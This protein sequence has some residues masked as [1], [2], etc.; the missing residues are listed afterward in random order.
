MAYTQLWPKTF[1]IAA[2]ENMLDAWRRVNKMSSCL[3]A[4]TGCDTTSKIA[5]K[6]AAL[7]GI[8]IPLLANF[9][10][11]QL[12][13]NTIQLAETFFVKCLK[14]SIQF[15]TFD[16]LRIDTFDNNALKIDFEK[17]ACTIHIRRRYYQMQLWI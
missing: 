8:R 2:E 5:T 15:E 14:P 16:E 1:N 7:N 17:T 6:F 11:P 12:T 13:D 10:F 3:H 4:L 9:N